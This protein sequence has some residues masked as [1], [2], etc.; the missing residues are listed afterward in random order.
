MIALHTR[1]SG[2]ASVLAERKLVVITIEDSTE[3]SSST[4]NSEL[5]P[6]MSQGSIR[7]FVQDQKLVMHVAADDLGQRTVASCLE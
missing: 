4:W 7:H 3:C 1:E 6:G 5:G 2:N